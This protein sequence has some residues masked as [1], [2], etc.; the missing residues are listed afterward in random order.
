MKHG[1][2][3]G[4]GRTGTHA[5]GT[6]GGFFR[7]L[8]AIVGIGG[9]RLLDVPVDRLQPNPTQP[10]RRFEARAM[11]SLTASV[12]RDGVLQPVLVRRVGRDLVL[13]AGERRWRAAK[14]AGLRT[15]PALLRDDDADPLELAL[16]ENLQRANLHPLDEA[17]AL[18]ELKERLGYTD[19]DLATL[20]GKSR[21]TMSEMLALVRLPAD[22]RV[23][24][25]TSDRWTRSQLLEVARA[26]DADGMR[27][28]WEGLQR[29][30]GS[31]RTLRR[32]RRGGA[33]V[34]TY[35]EAGLRV[36]VSVADGDASRDRLRRAL[37]RALRAVPPGAS[38][39]APRDRRRRA[40]TPPAPP[41]A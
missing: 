27:R 35:E 22:V 10:R 36:Q 21:A 6:R 29:G 31:V 13:V 14:A 9:P 34:F 32:G 18:A 15:I 38:A 40:C 8:G 7:P 28:A 39:A 41:P 5:P 37:R 12:R 30:R 24:C 19:R 33:D 23:A 4:T 1:E 20:M 17:E 25:R 16:L 2:Q 26:G 11:R 3:V